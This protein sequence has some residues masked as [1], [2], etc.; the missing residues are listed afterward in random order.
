MSKAGG[1]LPAR[2][3]TN[4]SAAA[5]DGRR[6]I[7]RLERWRESSGDEDDDKA[8]RPRK[9]AFVQLSRRC[10]FDSPEHAHRVPRLE[11][12]GARG[13]T[14]RAARRQGRTSTEGT[15]GGN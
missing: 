14:T 1:Q 15:R 8:G 9:A 10:T 4:G 13:A 11:R 7:R 3:Q 12:A 2:P 5:S 6:E